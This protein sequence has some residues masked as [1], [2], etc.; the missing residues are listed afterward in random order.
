MNLQQLNRTV[1][2][3]MATSIPPQLL[4]DTI[5]FIAR[6]SPAIRALR[7]ETPPARRTLRELDDEELSLR[8]ADELG[9]SPGHAVELFHAVAR[10]LHGALENHDRE[11]FQRDLP[12]RIVET[13]RRCQGLR[14]PPPD[15]G[16]RLADAR[17]GSA[18]PVATAGPAQR[19]SIA[20]EPQPKEY[21][22][23]SSSAGLTQERLQR[24][25]AEGKPGSTRPVSEEQ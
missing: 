19:D 16:H 5:T 6:Y 17:P 24:T 25:L 9:L 2:L 4:E 8:L 10:A 13:F 18:R 22:K 11:A 23:L 20:G 12:P 1:Q 15:T 21:I 3:R 7:P 14:T